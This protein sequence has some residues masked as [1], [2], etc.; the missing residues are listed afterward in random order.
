MSRL[1]ITNGSAAV[2]L[3]RAAGV[4]DFAFSW[5]DVLHEGNVPQGLSLAELSQVRAKFIAEQGW[6]TIAQAQD[7][8]SQR[9]TFL[10]SYAEYER[11]VL[12]FEHDL[13]DQLQLIQ[14]L[15]W[16]NQ[17][18]EVE[19]TLWLAGVDKHIGYHSPDKI[20]ALLE[21]AKPISQTQLTL[22]S[23]AWWA[24]RQE[25]PLSLNEFIAPRNNTLP[26]LSKAILRLL[27]EFPEIRSGLPLTEQLILKVLQ[28]NCLSAADVFRGY[29]ELEEDEFLGDLIFWSKVNRMA[30]SHH[31]LVLREPDVSIHSDNARNV[32]LEMTNY[33]DEVLNLKANWFYDNQLTQ[34]IGGCRL[35][36]NHQF[37]FDSQQNMVV[38]S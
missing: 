27:Q 35:N 26:F 33:A 23:E 25:I 14:I 2:D 7:K 30:E 31:P 37:V 3:V 34:W 19:S 28:N 4:K 9:N 11:V 29:C 32:K 20:P 36:I 21:N 6:A 24:F 12:F 18:P 10:G 1:I 5:D 13:Y 22:A 16:F 15:D 38:K 8:F 17:L